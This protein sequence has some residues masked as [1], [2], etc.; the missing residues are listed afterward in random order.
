[1]RN[2]ILK[3]IQNEG[4]AILKLHDKLNELNIEHEFIDRKEE[5]I[6]M[7]KEKKEI[8]TINERF[9]FDYQIYLE[10]NG[11]RIS[12]IQSPYSYCVTK[13]LIEVYNFQH[14]PVV[15]DHEMAAVL[16][17][18][19]KLN[20]YIIAVNAKNVEELEKLQEILQSLKEDKQ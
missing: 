16:I 9:P 1:M 10:E 14:E 18:K 7:V 8:D 15:L 6:K 3:K 11:N 4:L 2:E 17:R 12:L 19:N 20:S 5:Q 13:N